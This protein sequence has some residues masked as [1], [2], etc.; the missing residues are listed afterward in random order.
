[1]HPGPAYVSVRPGVH[2]KFEAYYVVDA[3]PGAVIYKGLK[4]GVTERDFRAAVASGVTEQVEALLNRIAA[5]PGDTHYL[6]GGTCHAIGA[7]VLLAE[8]QTPSDT[9][10]RLFDWGRSGRELHIDEGMGSIDFCQPDLSRYEPRTQFSDGVQTTT[11]HVASDHFRID[12]VIAPADY[13]RTVGESGPAIWIVLE[14]EGEIDLAG[15]EESVPFT[16]GESLLI[17][18]NLPDAQVRVLLDSSWL[19]VTLP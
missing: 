16:R 9:T 15:D 2:P 14:G 11:R 13:R 5:I 8:I 19:E 18:G 4:R 10:F 7:G 6:P 17:P 3:V 1:M 12:E